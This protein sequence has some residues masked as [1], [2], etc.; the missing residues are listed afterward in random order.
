M[1]DRCL[2]L[3]FVWSQRTNLDNLKPKT[4]LNNYDVDTLSV[5]T[6]AGNKINEQS[7]YKSNNI[8]L[9]RHLKAGLE[10]VKKKR[11]TNKVLFF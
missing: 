7:K 4:N 8:D 3:H 9:I 5:G 6:Y 1:P 10:Y 2:L 11:K